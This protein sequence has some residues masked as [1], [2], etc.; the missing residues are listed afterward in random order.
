MT[1]PAAPGRDATVADVL[2]PDVATMD[3]T[4]AERIVAEAART[5]TGFVRMHAAFPL[6][7]ARS[8]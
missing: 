4:E 6:A 5:V 7:L 8:G 3:L 2:P 1:L